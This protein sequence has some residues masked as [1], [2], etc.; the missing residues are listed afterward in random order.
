MLG[1]RLFRLTRR[2]L[3]TS[4]WPQLFQS[5]VLLTNVALIVGATL[6]WSS[7]TRGSQDFVTQLASG[8][9]TVVVAPS[10]QGLTSSEIERI[11]Q[12]E[13]VDSALC[14]SWVEGEVDGSSTVLIGLRSLGEPVSALGETEDDLGLVG[15][16]HRAARSGTGGLRLTSGLRDIDIDPDDVSVVDTEAARAVNSGNFVV[17]PLDLLAG[18]SSQQP[19]AVFLTRSPQ[20]SADSL[21]ESLHQV[22]GEEYSVMSV[23]QYAELVSRQYQLMATVSA[24]FTAGAL[25]G[26]MLLI[27]ISSL[28]E[29]RRKQHQYSVLRMLGVRRAA[30]ASWSLGEQ[31]LVLLPA[32]VAG[33]WLGVGLAGA[34]LDWLPPALTSGLPITPTLRIAWYQVGALLAAAYLAAVLGRAYAT[35][36]VLGDVDSGLVYLRSGQA[37]LLTTPRRAVVVG[38]AIAL[39]CAAGGAALPLLRGT[40]LG[41][42]ALWL[43]PACL[44]GLARLCRSAGLGLR[45]VAGLSLLGASR[46]LRGNVVLAVLVAAVNGMLVASTAPALA[47]V[48]RGNQSVASLLR[49][50]Y[51]LQSAPADQLPTS[52]FLSY[53]DALGL[54][55]A[56]AIKQVSPGVLMTTSLASGQFT[57]QGVSAGSAMPAAYNAGAQKVRDLSDT[58]GLTI[59]S[60]KAAASLDLAVGDQLHLPIGRGLDLTVTA[61]ADYI[62]LDDGQIVVSM[63]DLCEVQDL[64]Q[65]SYVEIRSDGQS[66]LTKDDLGD[67][68]YLIP[69]DQVHLNTAEAENQALGASIASTSALSVM[70]GL[71]LVAAAAAGIFGVYRNEIDSRRP[72]LT[73]LGRMG[74]SVRQVLVAQLGQHLVLGVCASALGGFVGALWAGG[75]TVFLEN[76]LALRGIGAE[77]TWWMITAS[78]GTGLVVLT[79]AAVA[80]MATGLRSVALRG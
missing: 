53:Q 65:V 52:G 64:C 10:G 40:L 2:S 18:I 27:Y 62:G 51:Y 37:G 42:A 43:V 63:R 57:I 38:A 6:V 13:G 12:A 1:I 78:A 58:R 17:L 39:C 33:G 34:L 26:G 66:A 24:V 73:S 50:D 70:L 4:V 76:G 3:A 60:R 11:S 61:V 41:T 14:A 71:Q 15:L 9:D 77:L 67:L 56:P 45:G 32:L 29:V 75:L 44:V 68:D 79:S 7:L 8:A 49:N 74:L 5:L 22:L 80:G 21:K 35:R 72:T 36:K 59:I 20:A 55:D 23:A 48:E 19:Q 46:R 16:G 47:L 69:E 54:V 25:L 31:A 28:I 30:I